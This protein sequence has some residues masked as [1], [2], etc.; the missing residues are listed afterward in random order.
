[1]AQELELTPNDEIGLYKY[2]EASIILECSQFNVDIEKKIVELAETM[3]KRYNL[4]YPQPKFFVGGICA[5]ITRLFEKEHIGYSGI[6]NYYLRKYPRFKRTYSLEESDPVE[7]RRNVETFE[8]QELQE[9][10]YEA[11]K[12]SAKLEDSK[13]D[14]DK[15]KNRIKRRADLEG[16]TLPEYVDK[17]KRQF[18][19]VTVLNK[20]KATPTEDW[21][22][23]VE[24][25]RNTLNH[26][27]DS[28]LE[29]PPETDEDKTH[30]AGVIRTFIRL[31][32]PLVNNRYS[33]DW[34][35]YF[36]IGKALCSVPA[37]SAAKADA[38]VCEVCINCSKLKEL[39]GADKYQLMDY[40]TEYEERDPANN[41]LI[42]VLKNIY[43]CPK[44]G[45]YESILSGV[46]TE[47]LENR[48]PFVYSFAEEVLRNIPA[49]WEFVN[50]WKKTTQKK[51]ALRKKR[52]YDRFSHES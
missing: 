45:G 34:F 28:L 15:L 39:N 37:G 25:A 38:V 12:K 14:L 50:R 17:N 42:R 32:D 19:K 20:P 13:S 16:I 49:F 35:G 9:L 27:W 41:A 44:C 7:A 33:S 3:E 4:E 26:Y 47:H 1:M 31:F 46:S 24:Y 29:E 48:M 22:A 11:S 52:G 2:K 23:V 43:R 18:S 6:V 8:T 51:I 36:K 40:Y 30:Y 5:D 10:Y 21:K